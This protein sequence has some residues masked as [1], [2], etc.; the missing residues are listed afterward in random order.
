[1]RSVVFVTQQKRVGNVLFKEDVAELKIGIMCLKHASRILLEHD[2]QKKRAYA[3]VV[4][5]FTKSQ[6]KV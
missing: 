1:M 3:P 6:C 2:T 4:V 5:R